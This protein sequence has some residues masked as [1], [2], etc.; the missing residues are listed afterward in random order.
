MVKDLPVWIE[1]MVRK[2]EV[3]PHDPAW[4]EEFRRESALLAAV[5]SE[6]LVEIHHIGSTAMR[7]ICAKPVVD[8][9]SVVKNID[10]VDDFNPEMERLG[11]LPKGEASIP[12]RRLFIKPGEELRTHHVHVFQVGSPD[13]ARHLDFR[14]YMNAHPDEARM[15]SR[16]K[17]RLADQFP[18]D[19][20]SYCDG[21]DSFIQEVDRRARE[22]RG[23]GE[24]GE[25]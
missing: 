13:I 8:I 24:K 7:G 14:D 15:Y 6:E 25:C 12:G 4:E 20:D 2:I 22:W 23:G 17:E 19:A 3:I 10:K 5:F 18:H 16:L 9:V 21:K 1:S 11:Y